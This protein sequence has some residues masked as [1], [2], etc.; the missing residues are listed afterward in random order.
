MT[1][2]LS[3]AEQDFFDLFVLH[4]SKS[5]HL[6]PGCGR[7]VIINEKF[8]LDEFGD[9][10][11]DEGE[12]AVDALGDY[13][14]DESGSLVLAEIPRDIK[15]KWR[16]DSS[17]ITRSMIKEHLNG[18][19]C[20]GVFGDIK[21]KFFLLDLDL[22]A[23]DFDLFRRGLEC[24]VPAFHAR[25]AS[26][27]SVSEGGVHLIGIFPEIQKL[28]DVRKNLIGLLQTY[29]TLDL[30]FIKSDGSPSLKYILTLIM[31][32]ACHLPRIDSFY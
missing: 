12:W 25:F 14:L 3:L 4:G 24:L 29:N 6:A 20:F 1:S 26:H 21:T 22:H 19:T 32:S 28:K 5:R 9:Q 11:W 8:F 13:I 15:G 27:Y 18:K 16:C 2:P 30:G 31:V 7:P 23:G 17:P 10:V